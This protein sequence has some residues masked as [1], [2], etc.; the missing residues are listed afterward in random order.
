MMGAPDRRAAVM[1][2]G[3]TTWRGPRGPSGV[4]AASNP[5]RIRR[6]ISRSPA[7]PPR[8]LLPRAVE[9]PKR[10]MVRLMNSP[11]RCSLMRMAIRRPG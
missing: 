1:T 11:S 8:V 10:A 4:K 3:C 9:K 5:D 6:T 7:D 2:P